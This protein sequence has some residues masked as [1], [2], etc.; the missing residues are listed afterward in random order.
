M[1]GKI[2]VTGLGC[3]SAIGKNV[4]ENYFSLLNSKSGIGKIQFLETIHKE[5]FKVGEVKYSNDELIGLAGIDKGQLQNF[6][7][8][9][10][11]GIIASKEAVA[12]AKLDTEKDNHRIG[13]ISATTV[14]GMDRS[15]LEYNNPDSGFGYLKTHVS[16]ESTDSICEVLKLRGYRNTVST[17]CSSGANAII[18]AI[19]LINEN[20]IDKAIVGG[21]DSLSKFTLNGFNSLMILDK[22]YCKPFD[23]NR[24]GLNLG[25]GAAYIV[26]ESERTLQDKSKALCSISGYAN[27][28]DAY[29]Q[30]ASSPNG[31]GAYLS[32]TKAMKVANLKTDQIDYINVHG[33]GTPN[34]DQSE[35]IALE[36][37]FSSR[38]PKF[39]S[40]KS[41]TGHT[42]GAAASIE[43]IYS[44]LAIQ[45]GKIFPNL[46]FSDQIEDLN[47]SPETRVLD[48]D[49][50]NV[51]S[52][53]FGFG[54]NNSSIIFSK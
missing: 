32:M 28:N 3:I 14:G 43:A 4:E 10:L 20:I 48:A 34:N 42:L 38:V 37:I 45:H 26:I 7:R 19:R 39:S 16:G 33:T 50:L 2:F 15:E 25:E 23:Q 13:V 30:T 31:E 51:L 27:A 44:I 47:I 18:H 29:H 11:L 24:K 46:N 1:S 21:V 8:T 52:N 35:G 5:T 6:T 36:R 17:A 22:D 54:G 53:S 9:A 12:H 49:V 41:F 40:T